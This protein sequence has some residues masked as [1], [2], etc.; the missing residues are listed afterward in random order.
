MGAL[1]HDVLLQPVCCSDQ[2]VALPQGRPRPGTQ[3]RFS[4]KPGR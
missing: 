3:Y 4:N 2:P 1:W